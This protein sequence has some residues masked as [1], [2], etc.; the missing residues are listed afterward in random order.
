[1]HVDQNCAVPSREWKSF[2]E[3]AK[4]RHDTN[5]GRLLR[6]QWHANGN[7]DWQNSGCFALVK[8][9]MGD[10]FTSIRHISGMEVPLPRQLPLTHTLSKNWIEHMAVVTCEEECLELQVKRV[11]VKSG[12]WENLSKP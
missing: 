6:L 2:I 9:A 4:S 12:L 7:V 1:M 5:G 11:F 10:A 8:G 3:H